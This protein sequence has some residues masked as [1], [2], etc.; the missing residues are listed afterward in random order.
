[1]PTSGLRGPWMIPPSVAWDVPQAFLLTDAILKLFVNI[2]SDMVVFPAQI[3]KHLLSEL[4][5]MATEKILMS[6]VEKGE[7]RQEM[8]ESIKAHSLAAGKAVKVDGVANDLL[9]RL[10]DG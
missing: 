2:T 7:S 10:A 3:K 1:M 6:A 9:Q 8:H 4:P 5:F